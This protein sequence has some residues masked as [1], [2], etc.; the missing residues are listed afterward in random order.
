MS[1]GEPLHRFAVTWNGVRVI[2]FAVFLVSLIPVVATASPQEKPVLQITD[3]VEGTIVNPG[4][5][6]K[7]R[8]TSPTPA[9]F[10]SVAVI[11]EKIGFLGTISSLPGELSAQIPNDIKLG[12]HELSVVGTPQSGKERILAT[13]QID[14]ERPDLP[15]SMSSQFS[16]LQ[17][18]SAGE[19]VPLDVLAQFFDRTTSPITTA[20]YDVTE[21]TH[22]SFSSANTEV[23]TVDSSGQVTAVAPGAGQ[24]QVKYTLGDNRVSIGI[25]VHVPDPNGESER[26]K[27]IFSI[28]PGGQKIEP[29]GSASFKLTVS[30]FSNFPGEIEFSAHG[31]PDDTTARF[32]PVSAHAPGSVTLTISTSQS[33]PVDA[34]P[35]YITARSGEL[36]SEASLLLLV[37]KNSR[38]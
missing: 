36:H 7:V 33:T 26:N 2:S 14:V 32:T 10:Q 12:R 25:P 9:L 15:A 22:I 28:A 37:T 4:Q 27:F 1:M 16:G 29:G 38:N 17:L 5:T 34:Y 8:V 20:T 13:I 23:A 31:L 35:V 11:G 19:Q 21:S 30:S 18:D 6:L 3:P 24:I